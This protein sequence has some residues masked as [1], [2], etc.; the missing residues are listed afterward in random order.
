M[1]QIYDL[2]IVGRATWD[3]HS[4]N[5]EGSI[6]NVTEP[7]TVMLADGTKSDGVSGEMLKHAHVSAFWQIGRATSFLLFLACVSMGFHLSVRAD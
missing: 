7:R 5:N 2:A 6:G 3:L 1:Q 4:L